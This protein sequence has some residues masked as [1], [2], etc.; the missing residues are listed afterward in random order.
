MKTNKTS[1]SLSPVGAIN[2]QTAGPVRWIGTSGRPKTI[3]YL[4]SLNPG[5][6]DTYLAFV[7]PGSLKPANA[8]LL[9]AS[10]TSYDKAGRELGV[11]ATALAQSVDLAALIRAAQDLRHNVD[12]SS[13]NNSKRSTARWTELVIRLDAELAKLPKA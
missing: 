3:A 6:A 4:E 2:Q 7:E 12:V 11:D 10:Y 13:I 1:L 9:A 8:T 5:D